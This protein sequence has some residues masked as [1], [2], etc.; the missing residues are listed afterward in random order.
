MNQVKHR[1]DRID[2]DTY[3]MQ[4]AYSTAQRSPDPNTQVGAVIVDDMNRIVSTGYN[5]LPYRMDNTDINWAREGDELEQKYKFVIHAEQ[6]ALLNAKC[7]LT[8]HVIYVTLFPCATCAKL[9]SQAGITTVY[10]NENNIPDTDFMA[11][12]HILKCSNISVIKLNTEIK[13]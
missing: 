12:T 11:S 8:N 4:I 10:Y 5:G 6:N 1:T 2:W 13:K 3:F 9:I 7:D